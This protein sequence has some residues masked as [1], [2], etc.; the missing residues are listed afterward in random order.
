MRGLRVYVEGFCYFAGTLSAAALNSLGMTQRKNAA[1]PL[2][3]YIQSGQNV[4]CS[5]SSANAMPVCGHKTFI[6]SM[7]ICVW[8]LFADVTF[9]GT[10]P[11]LSINF[12]QKLKATKIN[13]Q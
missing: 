4:F 7:H 12:Y 9:S 3:K 8:R 11:L 10:P 13:Q 2:N 5:T 6:L 1:P